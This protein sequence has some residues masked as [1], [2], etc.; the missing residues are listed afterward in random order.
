MKP[1][2][3]LSEANDNRKNLYSFLARVYAKEVDVEFL[4]GLK[5]KR[6][7]FLASAHDSEVQEAEFADGFR[8]L[9]EYAGTLRDDELEKARLELAVEYAGVFL[10]AWKGVAHPSE[11]AY[12]TEGHLI[13]QKPR[14]EVLA[15]FRSMGL[16]KSEDF[17]EPEDHVALEL[18]F[19]AHMSEKT[20]NA[21]R[22]GKYADARKYLEIQK[23]FLKTHLGWWVPKLTRDIVKVARQN[24][25]KAI[26]KITDG[27]I[28]IDKSILD[29]LLDGL[30]SAE[31]EPE[32]E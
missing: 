23:D 27:Y 21:L 30:A 4:R 14:D 17:P 6:E 25:Y 19:M 29:E 2:A 13:M 20:G 5:E 31:A 1:A 9:A 10:G 18:Q 22:D 12:K 32:R 3:E 24:F 26:A 11:S 28:R 7:F 16:Q 15:K 8:E